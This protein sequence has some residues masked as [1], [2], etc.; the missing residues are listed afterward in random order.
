[1]KLNL[2]VKLVIQKILYVMAEVTRILFFWVPI[3]KNKIFFMS[4][5]GTKYACNQ[6]YLTEYIIK[7]KEDY[8]LVWVYINE[9]TKNAIDDQ[10]VKVKKHSFAYFS[11]TFGG[12]F[13]PFLPI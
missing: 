7:N 9:K 10:C 11:L 6:R 5:A 4:Y 8:E 3:K 1:M 13:T 12:T 2:L